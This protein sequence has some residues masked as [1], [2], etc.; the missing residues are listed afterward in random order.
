M[1]LPDAW[2][3]LPG[4]DIYLL[5][6]VLR[7]IIRPDARI[8]D[9]GC[10]SGRNLPF[11]AHAGM[12]ITAVDADPG[13]VA[14][15]SR[16]LSQSPG[17]HT[18]T[19]AT[20]PHLGLEQRFDAVVCVAVLH[21]APDQAA[22]QAWADACWERLLPGGIFLARLATRIAL[23]EAT[24]GFAYRPTLEDLESCE[25]RWGASRVD[26]LKTT[27]VEDLRAMS[28]WILRKPA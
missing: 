13:A 10:G 27:L 1:K 14:S 4:A 25:Q 9:V 19:V 15:C 28:T 17:R 26:P 24:G 12:T 22:F 16:L 2:S 21:F 5:D 3:P 23:P 18:C 20:L 7:G 11:L 8:L 6:I